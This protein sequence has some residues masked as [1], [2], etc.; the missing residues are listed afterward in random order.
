MKI[1][2]TYA[3]TFVFIKLIFFNFTFSDILSLYRALCTLLFVCILLVI[4]K[5]ALTYATT[6]FF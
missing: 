4:L 3:T 2:L 6:L 1:A 5:I